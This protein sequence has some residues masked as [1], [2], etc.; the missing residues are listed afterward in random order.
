MASV[1]NDPASSASCGP[2][3]AEEIAALA[4]D[5]P[6]FEHA[7]VYGSALVAPASGSVPMTDLVFA[8]R[9][10]EAWHALNLEKHAA[11]YSPLG[12]L[13]PRCV[14]VPSGAPEGVCACVCVWVGGW[15]GGWLGGDSSDDGR[16]V[17]GC[18]GVWVG[19][20]VW[21]GGS[22]WVCVW[23]WVCV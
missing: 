23:G 21:V 2:L 8:V 19:V 1:A 14:A 20:R 11:H 6:H 4:A 18:V 12:M 10:A 16:G 15:V 22:V 3:S 13:G 9:E 5:F 17:C 7:F